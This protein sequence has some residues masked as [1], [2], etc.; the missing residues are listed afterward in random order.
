MSLHKFLKDK[1]LRVD[2]LLD[3][4]Y[5][6]GNKINPEVIY[7]SNVNKGD[8]IKINNKEYTY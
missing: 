8:K 4:I 7:S 2:Y 5:V 6:N 3:K 1:G